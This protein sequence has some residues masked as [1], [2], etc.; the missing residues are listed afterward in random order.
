MV[1]VEL[2]PD[3]ASVGGDLM[4]CPSPDG[5]ARSEAACDVV[6]PARDVD[7]A[8]SIAEVRSE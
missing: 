5:A 3:G 1:V 2:G 6:L 8:R 4:A 7:V